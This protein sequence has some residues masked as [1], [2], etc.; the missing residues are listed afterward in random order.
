LLGSTAL[1]G[2]EVEKRRGDE[3]VPGDVEGNEESLE[4]L[5]MVGVDLY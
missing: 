4:W 1:L 2:D 3:L 5:L